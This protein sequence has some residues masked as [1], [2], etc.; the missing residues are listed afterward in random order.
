MS[1]LSRAAVLTGAALIGGGLIAAAPAATAAPA[2]AQHF[3]C[4][5]SDEPQISVGATGPAV[6]KAQCELNSVLDRHVTA[7]GKFG[8]KTE[9]ATIAF[10]GC[11][12]LST[13]GIIGPDT[14]GALD[15]WWWNDIDCHK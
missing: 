4:K 6:E 11:A 1:L 7:D 5:S 10:Q 12:G 9:S 15:L 2:Q 8:P 13:D 3:H 14:W